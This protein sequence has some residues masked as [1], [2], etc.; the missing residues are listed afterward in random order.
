[1]LRASQTAEIIAPALGLPILY[2]DEV[3]EW[4]F[5]A[6]EN[7]NIDEYV[8]HFKSIPNDQKPFYQVVPRAESWEVV[9]CTIAPSSSSL[10]PPR[11]LTISTTSSLPDP[12]TNP[13]ISTSTIQ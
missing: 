8:E 1:M 4:R 12:Y 13:S 2:D 11:L 6:D 9:S 7:L 3:Q 5:P 10:V